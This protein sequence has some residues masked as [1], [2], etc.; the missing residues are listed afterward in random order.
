MNN[1][2]KIL[3]SFIITIFIIGMLVTTNATSITL[4]ELEEFIR[5]ESSVDINN[6]TEADIITL[7][8]EISEKYTNNELADLIE[9]YSAELQKEGI[10][11]QT[12]DAGVTLLRT[13]DAEEL[14]AILE[15]LDIDEIEERLS[16]GESLD[17]VI[18]DMDI[19]P[20]SIIAKLLLANTIF[21][22]ILIVAL[23]IGIYSI[24]IRWRIYSKAGKHGWAAIIPIYRDVVWYKVAGIT[25]WVLLLLLIPLLGWISLALIII[26][27]KF[28]MAKRFEKGALFGLGLWILPIIFESVLA[29]SRNIKYNDNAD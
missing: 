6:I 8:Q 4:N 16:K 19:N 10:D 14:K 1:C 17:Q 24:I 2:K 5:T 15:Q 23:I 21:K 28:T 7:Y 13:T 9:D 18:A 25:P 11:K 29:F 12:I 26:V 3:L 20:I 27:S 22:A